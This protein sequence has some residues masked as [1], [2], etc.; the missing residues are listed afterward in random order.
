MRPFRFCP[1]C[2]SEVDPPDNESGARCP[3]CGRVWYRNAAPSAGAAITAGRR[4]LVTVRGREP[5]K[6]RIDLP[7]GFLRPD[8]DPISGLRREVAEE[9]GVE[10][11]VSNGDF[12][13]GAPHTYGEEGDWVLALGFKARLTGGEPRPADDVAG[14]EWVAEEELDDLD[15]AWPHDLELVR[16]AL[17]DGA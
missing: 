14:I 16:K 7:G 12:V 17:S 15:W 5:K 10:I 8:E 9:L 6:G 11:D 13:Q 4:A 2:A 1:A 3:S